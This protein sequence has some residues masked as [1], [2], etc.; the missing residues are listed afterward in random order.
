MV[1]GGTRDPDDLAA[2]STL[3]GERDEEVLTHD[4]HANLTAVT[5]RRVPVLS[6]AQIAQLPARHVLLIRRGL[7]PAIGKVQMAWRRRDV[8]RYHS[9]ERW[10]HRQQR[11]AHA[12]GRVEAL[13]SGWAGTVVNRLD[14][15]TR[16]APADG[17]KDR[18]DD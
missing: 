15:R 5:T 2:Y 16:P 10:A 8:R 3:G 17:W 14:R 18:A 9:Y 13:L 6:P 7:P 12:A 1:Y 4:D 11:M